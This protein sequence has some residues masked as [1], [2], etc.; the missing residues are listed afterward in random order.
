[1]YVLLFLC[2]VV[3]YKCVCV[4]FF[5]TAQ[6]HQPRQKNVYHICVAYWPLTRP[7]CPKKKCTSVNYRCIR[8]K[9]SGDQGCPWLSRGWIE[10]E[11]GLSQEVGESNYYITPATGSSYQLERRCWG[12]N[13]VPAEAGP[14]S[15]RFGSPGERERNSFIARRAGVNTLQFCSVSN[16]PLTQ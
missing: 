6:T 11:L 1:M 10:C 9:I 14:P 2:L 12:K 13:H 15:H 8:S 7:S 3:F 5:K 16:L 4:F